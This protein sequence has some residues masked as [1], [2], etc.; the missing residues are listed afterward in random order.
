M[1]RDSPGREHLTPA[2]RLKTEWTVRIASN[3]EAADHLHESIVSGLAIG[4]RVFRAQDKVR[5]NSDRGSRN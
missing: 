3:D 2:G 5:G 4:S 1:L